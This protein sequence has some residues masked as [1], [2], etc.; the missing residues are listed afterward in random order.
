MLIVGAVL[1]GVAGIPAL[2]TRW[3]DP[4]SGW[5]ALQTGGRA[6]MPKLGKYTKGLYIIQYTPAYTW[7]PTPKKSTSEFLGEAVIP[8][9]E[10]GTHFVARSGC[11]AALLQN[12]AR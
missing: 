4:L 3:T 7:E 2:Q 11:R 5:S 8:E 6:D 10:N 1:C 12:F 9:R